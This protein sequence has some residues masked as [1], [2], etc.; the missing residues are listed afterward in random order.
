MKRFRI[1]WLLA[2]LAVMSLTISP[3]AYASWVCEG[4]SC[5]TSFFSCCCVSPEQ[6][7]DPNCSEKRESAGAAEAPCATECGCVLTVRSAD[8]TKSSVDNTWASNLL[9]AAA[10]PKGWIEIEAPLRS[11]VPT[12]RETRGPPTGPASRR[13]PG[14][15]AP[16][17]DASSRIGY[18]AGRRTTQA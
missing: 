5:G 16:P 12:P 9:Q 11:E 10:L 8:T 3:Q 17:A 7:Q 1:N 13:P 6:V 2:L 18:F 4:R 15:R 14:L